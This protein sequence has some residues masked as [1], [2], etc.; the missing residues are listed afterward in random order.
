MLCPEGSATTFRFVLDT[1]EVLVVEGSLKVYPLETGPGQ[2]SS[3]ADKP[4]RRSLT[5]QAAAVSLFAPER[6]Q[7]LELF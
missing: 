6:L 7:Q 5:R 3:S 4:E 1:G 2:E